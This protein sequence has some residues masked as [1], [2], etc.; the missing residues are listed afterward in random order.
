MI[1]LNS[2]DWSEIVWLPQNFALKNQPCNRLYPKKPAGMHWLGYNDAV[3]WL[4]EAKTRIFQPTA[5]F[6]IFEIYLYFVCLPAVRPGCTRCRAPEISHDKGNGGGF[7]KMLFRRRF[8]HCA[9]TI[10]FI[11][12][13]LSLFFFIP[14]ARCECHL[15]R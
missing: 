11:L 12:L 14:L 7:T 4:N 13:S 15:R 6:E 8:T 2:R 9:M 10:P 3:S 5:N 1:V